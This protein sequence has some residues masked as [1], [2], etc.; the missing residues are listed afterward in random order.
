MKLTQ[1]QFYGKRKEMPIKLPP[2]SSYI[3]VDE[4]AIYIAGRNGVP[5][6]SIG[7]DF[8]EELSLSSTI[9]EST[10]ALEAH[11]NGMNDVNSSE[12]VVITIQPNSVEN[13]PV[14]STLSYNQ[15][16]EGKITIAYAGSASGDA[17]S[18]FSKT[19]VI[20]LWHKSLDNWVVLNK[21]NAIDSSL[22]GE[23]SGAY[24][25]GNIVGISQAD[26]DA[27]SPVSTTTYIIE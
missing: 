19:D 3:A 15:I 7:G 20:T 24:L 11:R 14:K 18:T 1:N 10:N 17:A 13:I 5:E 8:E 27:G 25:L 6:L 26:Y 2:G 22:E 21:P 23:P 16:G 4:K 9:V 12:E